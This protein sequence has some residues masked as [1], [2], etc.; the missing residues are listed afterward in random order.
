[1]PAIMIVLVSLIVVSCADTS[2]KVRP[3]SKAPQFTLRDGTGKEFSLRDELKNKFVVIIFMGT[4]CPASNGYNGR[5]TELYRDYGQHEVSFLGVN[6]NAGEGAEEVLEHAK[7]RNIGFPVLKDLKNVVA[8]AYGAQVTPEV[9]VIDRQGVLR[10]HGR[11]DDDVRG[12]NIT[13]QDLRVALDALLAGKAV[14]IAETRI[15]GCGIE[16]VKVKY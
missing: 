13:S 10:Y 11:I 7:N 5:M 16:R 6:S 8:D 3:G 12:R 15:F 9:F 2:A 4:H 14:P 1:M